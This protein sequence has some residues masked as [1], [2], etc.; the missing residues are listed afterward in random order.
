MTALRDRATSP[1]LCTPIVADTL[2]RTR[3]ESATISR[4]K[5]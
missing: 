4:I 2:I 3:P 1:A 5:T